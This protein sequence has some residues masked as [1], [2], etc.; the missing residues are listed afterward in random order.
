YPEECCGIVT[1]GEQSQTVHFCRNIQNS[2]HAE[3]PEAH[4]RD[5]RTAYAIDRKE[6]KGVV[7]LAEKNNEKVI[8]FYH[9]HT[10]L[11]AYFSEIDNEAQTVFGEPEFPDA[12]QLVISVKA[13]EIKDLKGFKWDRQK[14]SFVPVA[15]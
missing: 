12:L 10:D 13:G 6:L 14:K 8:V 4:P 1:G 11:D 7:S 9:S 5:A 2:L 15:L 3:D